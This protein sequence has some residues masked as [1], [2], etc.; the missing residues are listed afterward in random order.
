M[1]GLF[2]FAN[3]LKVPPCYLVSLC[4]VTTT[5][6]HSGG[7]WVLILRSSSSSSPFSYPLL[8]GGFATLK[9]KKKVT[10]G[11]RDKERKNEENR[12]RKNIV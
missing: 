8:V 1:R 5:T 7:K 6:T 12:E 11:K 4:E 10:R 9:E 3:V 2:K